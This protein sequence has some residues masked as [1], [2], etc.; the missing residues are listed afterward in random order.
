MVDKKDIIKSFFETEFQGKDAFSF[1]RI[2]HLSTDNY[3]V[4][5]TDITKYVYDNY[6]QIKDDREGNINPV[7][8]KNNIA[9]LDDYWK[10]I[11]QERGNIRNELPKNSD[12]ADEIDK[13]ENHWGQIELIP[14]KL[15]EHIQLA[16]I[17]YKVFMEEVKKATEASTKM[18]SA[19][20]EAK[21]KMDSA[22]S[23]MEKMNSEYIAILGIFSSLIFGLFGG[24][25]FFKDILTGVAHNMPISVTIINSSLFMLGL[26]AIIFLLLQSIAIMS[27]R[28]ILNCGCSSLKSCNHTFFLRY[29]TFTIIE[30]F[31]V[32]ILLCSMGEHILNSKAELYGNFKNYFGW[33]FIVV[34]ISIVGITIFITFF[35]NNKIK[36]TT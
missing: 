29:K 5:Y 3:T 18:K 27:N 24:V 15:D 23:K 17:Q 26:I 2:M 13:I 8:W 34:A 1:L 35:K 21:K 4:Y 19:M 10:K 30:G 22:N 25:D 28:N 32:T 12:L 11:Y 36:A 33:S 7:F 9:F 14:S 31:L 16:M 6:D 20:D